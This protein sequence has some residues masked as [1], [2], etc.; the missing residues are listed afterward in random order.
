MSTVV[1]ALLLGYAAPAHAST[2][3]QFN[4]DMGS[5]GYMYFYDYPSRGSQVYGPVET[6]EPHSAPWSVTLTS[7]GGVPF[8]SV[9]QYIQITPVANGRHP[10][11][12]FTAYVMANSAQTFNVEVID[13]T[14]WSWIAVSAWTNKY[15]NYTWEKARSG[16]FLPTISQVVVRVSLMAPRQ[17]STTVPKAVGHVDDFNV[18][19]TY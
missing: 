18:T 15:Q 12:Q 14:T 3:W 19:C 5:P 10:D 11:C 17:F 7:G 1:V 2:T 16:W 8:A 6:I 4:N 13:P 9:Y